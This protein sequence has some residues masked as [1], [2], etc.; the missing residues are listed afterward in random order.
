LYGQAKTDSYYPVRR[1]AQ[2]L[3]KPWIEGDG[4]INPATARISWQEPIHRI[5]FRFWLPSTTDG[6][7]VRGGVR[8]F[9]DMLL[10]G[11]LRF[12][13]QVSSEAP[14][15][16]GPEVRTV[17]AMYRKIFASYAHEDVRVVRPFISHIETLGDRYL[18]DVRNLRSGEVWSSKIEDMIRE[19]DIFQLFWSSNSMRSE[20][21][22]KEWEY[23]LS[24]PR[25]LFV[26]PFHW[27]EPMPKDVKEGLPPSSLTRLHFAKLP[28]FT[29]GYGGYDPSPA[30]PDDGPTYAPPAPRSRSIYPWR[31]IIVVLI[32]TIIIVWA[33]VKLLT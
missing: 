16:G 33:A 10:I 21:V 18:V 27:E 14:L 3:F 12:S 25:D 31:L 4:R 20:Y 30:Y 23:A 26:R 7:T 9:N 6:T 22:R 11:E 15:A 24:L 32:V 1:G 29:Y 19:A 8:V 28:E 17:S 5:E 2:L 13:V